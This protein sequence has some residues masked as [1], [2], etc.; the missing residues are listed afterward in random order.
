MVYGMLNLYFMYLIYNT[1]RNTPEA[2]IAWL[3]KWKEHYTRTS[4]QKNSFELRV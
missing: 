2:I 3:I 4:D 1:P